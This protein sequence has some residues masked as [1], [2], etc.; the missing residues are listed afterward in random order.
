MIRNRVRAVVAYLLILIGAGLVIPNKFNL[1]PS[2]TSIIVGIIFH[3]IGVF[4]VVGVGYRL[5]KLK[6]F[7]KLPR[8]IS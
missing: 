1:I 5:D 8:Y 7:R 3:L 4:M 2:R 6:I